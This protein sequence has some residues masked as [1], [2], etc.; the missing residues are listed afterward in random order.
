MLTGDS[1]FRNGQMEPCYIQSLSN[2]PAENAATLLILDGN[3]LNFLLFVSESI[4]LKEV[5]F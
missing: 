5:G 4:H 2:D 1:T 3:R